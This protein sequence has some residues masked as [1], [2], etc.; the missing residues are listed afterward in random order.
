[1]AVDEIELKIILQN[2]TFQIFFQDFN[3]N[4]KHILAQR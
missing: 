3:P 1:M 4:K 2:K